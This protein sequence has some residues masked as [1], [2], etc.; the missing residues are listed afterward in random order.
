MLTKALDP[1]RA[2]PP[3]RSTPCPYATS[4]PCPYAAAPPARGSSPPLVT[5][6][7]AGIAPGWS[8]SPPPPAA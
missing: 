8:G 7:Y 2:A 4:T 3:T 1:R 6:E 5:G